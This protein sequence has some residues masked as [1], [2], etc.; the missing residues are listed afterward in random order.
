MLFLEISTVGRFCQLQRFSEKNPLA[1][2]T[3][4]IARESKDVYPWAAGPVH[5]ATRDFQLDLHLV[6]R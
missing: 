5:V 4:N 2:V 1:S 3:Q 6:F